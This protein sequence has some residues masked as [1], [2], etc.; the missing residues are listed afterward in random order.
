MTD[1][2]LAGQRALEFCEGLWQRG[3]PWELES[4]EYERARSARLIAILAGRRYRRALELGCG[5]GAFTRLLAGV[6]DEVVAF[7]IAPAAIARARAEGP[8]APRVDFRVGNVMDYAWRAEGPWDLVVMNETICYLGWL[9]SFFDLGWLASELFAATADG[10]TFLMANSMDRVHDKLLLPHIIKTYRDLFL[11][12]GF[13]LEREEVSRGAKSGVEYEVLT[14]LFVK[15][16][17]A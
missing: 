10:G 9:Y 3:D 16:A 1:R 14:S 5:A 13:G 17:A 2:S 8:G 4:S 11:N 12:A 7:D 15:P 6:A